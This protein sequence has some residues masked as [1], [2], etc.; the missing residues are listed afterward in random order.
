MLCLPK[1]DGSLRTVFDCRQRNDNTIHDVSPFP[2]QE[3]IRM[4]VARAKY[5]SKIDL[6]DAYEQVRIVPEDVWKTA[7]STVYGTML[8]QVMQQGDCNAPST[9]QRLMTHIFREHIGKFLHVYLDDIFVFSDTIEEHQEHLRAV[10]ECLR[11]AELYLKAS[12][13]D[14]YSERTDCLGHIIDEQGLH[15]SADKMA[16][17]REWRTPRDYGDIQRFLGL[18]Q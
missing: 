4:D 3:Q 16:K 13:C 11:K 6:S 8:S 5:R 15:A 2:D 14:L 17:I 9:F 18:V 7:F 12:K 1:K 10:F